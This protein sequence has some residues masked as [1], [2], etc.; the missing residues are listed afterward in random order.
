MNNEI[1]LDTSVVIQIF[2]NDPAVKE[3]FRNVETVWMP[4]PV[5]AELAVGFSDAA[6]RPSQ[7][8]RF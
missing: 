7:K 5:I 1:A 6:P 8:T 3:R 4:V 2:D